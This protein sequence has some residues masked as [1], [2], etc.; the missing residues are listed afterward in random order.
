[1]T[2]TSK[3]SG[4]PSIQ[5]PNR[6]TTH[7]P[8]PNNRH[9]AGIRTGYLPPVKQPDRYMIYQQG[10]DSN[11]SDELGYFSRA[12]TSQPVNSFIVIYSLFKRT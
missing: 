3:F 10:N 12:L 11:L 4:V 7:T 2:G 6:S 9:H 1:M 5:H 8:S